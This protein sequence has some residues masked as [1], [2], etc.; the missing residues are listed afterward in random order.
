MRNHLTYLIISSFRGSEVKSS[1][2]TPRLILYP[3][4]QQSRQK[5]DSFCKKFINFPPVGIWKIPPLIATPKGVSKLPSPPNISPE[6]CSS[7]EE[8]FEPIGPPK[9]RRLSE[10]GDYHSSL[11]VPIKSFKKRPAST[12][13][14]WTPNL[15]IDTLS[16]F[17]SLQPPEVFA[18]ESSAD[19]EE[20]K[21][22][23]RDEQ[24][25]VR[26]LRKIA[27]AYESGDWWIQFE[28]DLWRIIID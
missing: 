18:D 16:P 21:G 1:T 4:V 26:S 14:T 17:I 5:D 24:T 8:S 11:S 9:R 27:K 2:L 10:A 22:G 3:S 7:G 6:T 15:N 19:E 20:P 28:K 12:S 23:V 13:S 25:L